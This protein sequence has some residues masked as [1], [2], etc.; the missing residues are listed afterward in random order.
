KGNNL[1]GGEFG[2]FILEA[3]K[4]GEDSRFRTWSDLGA[5]GALARNVAKLKGL[6]DD[7][8]DGRKI[9]ELAESGDE[10]CIKAI[11]EFYFNNAVGIFNLQYTYDPEKIV[12]GGAISSREDF[13]D[14]IN[15]KL[16]IIM[17][18]IA[19]AKVRPVIEKCTFENDANLL[20]ALFNYLQRNNI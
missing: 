20:G 11:D 7:E 2:Y 15:E 12:I 18:K 6:S 3:D 4:N 9:F 8:I 1:H 14:R 13:I 5:T 19:D 16:D 17:N 10:D